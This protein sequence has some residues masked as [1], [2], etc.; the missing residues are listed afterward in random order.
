MP[1]ILP[2]PAPRVVFADAE[3]SKEGRRRGIR[4]TASGVE[5]EEAFEEDMQEAA[6]D[7]EMLTKRAHGCPVPKPSGVMGEVLG[8]AKAPKERRETHPRSQ[9]EISETK[10]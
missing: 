9:I 10:R 3:I 6:D 4:R 2:C 1:H 7:R 8:F 5:I